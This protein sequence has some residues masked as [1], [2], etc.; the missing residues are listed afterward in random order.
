VPTAT[1]RQRLCSG[2]ETEAII[3]GRLIKVPKHSNVIEAYGAIEEAEALTARARLSLSSRGE[4]DLAKRLE[5][6]Q[7]A[8]RLLPAFLAGSIDAGTI[9]L[10]VEEA[11]QGL[12]EP[13]GWSLTGC[14][15][16]DPDIVLASTKLRA[17][18][19]SIARATSEESVVPIELAQAFSDLV[20]RITYTL[21]KIHWNLCPEETKASSIHELLEKS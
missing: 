16:E 14:T 7:K 20:T 10:L 18:E 19:R 5:K 2:L 12:Q 3:A 6:L 1:A 21:Y 15:P 4:K 17:A 8:I 13:K 9:L 11:S